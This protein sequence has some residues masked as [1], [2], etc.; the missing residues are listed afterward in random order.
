MYYNNRGT[1]CPKDTSIACLWTVSQGHHTSLSCRRTVSYGHLHSLSNSYGRTQ[2]GVLRTPQSVLVVVPMWVITMIA[3][4]CL[5]VLGPDYGHLSS[6]KL[7]LNNES[8]AGRG[9]LAWN[10]I[11]VY[12][13]GGTRPTEWCTPP[14]VS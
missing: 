14:V 7:R 10:Y 9:H 11:V 3:L 2:C 1:Q 12:V 13:R 4:S 5:L 6:C 8:T